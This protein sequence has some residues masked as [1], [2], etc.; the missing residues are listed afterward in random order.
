[1][2]LKDQGLWFWFVGR[3]QEADI[4]GLGIC[5]VWL[6]SYC[7]V[8]VASKFWV[9]VIELLDG[10]VCCNLCATEAVSLSSAGPGSCGSVGPKS[11]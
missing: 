4:V 9:M 10:L 6:N 11:F 3:G 1:M 7:S 5:K 2:G 8:V